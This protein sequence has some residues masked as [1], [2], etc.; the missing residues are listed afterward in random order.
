M[1][2]YNCSQINKHTDDEII[3]P[4]IGVSTVN[5]VVYYDRCPLCGNNFSPIVYALLLSYNVIQT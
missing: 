4:L 3:P 1:Y 5:G 2:C